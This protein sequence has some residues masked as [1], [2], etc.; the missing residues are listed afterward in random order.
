MSAPNAR[1]GATVL[2]LTTPQ[3]VAMLQDFHGCPVHELF[4]LIPSI[5][6][7]QWH[8]ITVAGSAPDPDGNVASGWS[9]PRGSTWPFCAALAAAASCC[10]DQHAGGAGN[11]IPHR[12]SAW[13]FACGCSTCRQGICA[14][15]SHQA[16]R[17]VDQGAQRRCG[18]CCP[19]VLPPLCMVHVADRAFP[20]WTAPAVGSLSTGLCRQALLPS[21]WHTVAPALFKCNAAAACAGAAASALHC[22]S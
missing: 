22:R 21:H 15:P 19:Y 14:H 8:P 2:Q 6:R 12:L 7:W 1:R 3:P 17:Q 4:M 9:Q 20:V 13:L 10:C 5:S 11:S 18:V 16:V